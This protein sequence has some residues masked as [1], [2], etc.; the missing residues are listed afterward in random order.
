MTLRSAL[1]MYQAYRFLTAIMQLEVPP[2]FPNNDTSTTTA[3]NLAYVLL[4]LI[5]C[6]RSI[7]TLNIRILT[8]SGAQNFLTISNDNETKVRAKVS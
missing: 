8:L 2:Y 1:T 5:I 4:L 3:D 7:A 6:H